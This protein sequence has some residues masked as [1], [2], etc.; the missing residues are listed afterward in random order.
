[1][2][3]RYLLYIILFILV[4]CKS[5]NKE[6]QTQVIK[7]DFYKNIKFNHLLVVVDDTTYNNLFED[8]KILNDFSRNVATDVD[9]GEESWSGKYLYGKNHYIEFFKL[10]S[11]KGLKFGYTGLAFMTN[12]L[13]TLDSV[14]TY[15]NTT[16]DTI[17]LTKRVYVKDGKTTPWFKEIT[18]PNPDSLYI[19]PWL[20]ENEKEMMYR[21]GFAEEDLLHKIEYKDY[22]KY[23]QAKR[24]GISPDSVKY[25]KAFDKVTALH[26]RFSEAELNLLREYL[27]AFGFTEKGNKFIGSDIEINYTISNSAHYIVDQI[28]FSLLKSLPNGTHKFRNLE[29]IVEGDKASLK[30]NYKH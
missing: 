16:T 4:G 1:M 19:L 28:D 10:S 6:G 25:E 30:F 2:R 13:G 7:K 29:F 24:E 15:W 23:V 11:Y 12:K 14:H 22:M 3:I 8:W 5:S 18:I 9:A 20:M 21:V 26:F 27:I 17:T